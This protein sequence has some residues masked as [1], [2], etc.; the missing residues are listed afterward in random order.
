MSS[1]TFFLLLC[2]LPALVSGNPYSKALREVEEWGVIPHGLIADDQTH[3]EDFYEV[4]QVSV[5]E[6]A[7]FVKNLR[8]G[9]AFPNASEEVGEDEFYERAVANV[10]WTASQLKRVSFFDGYAFFPKNG[11]AQ[12]LRNE[13]A[14]LKEH[15]DRVA[16]IVHGNGMEIEGDSSFNVNLVFNRSVVLE[17]DVPE[18]LDGLFDR[19]DTNVRLDECAAAVDFELHGIHVHVVMNFADKL[20]PFIRDEYPHGRAFRSQV[21]AATTRGR[22][23]ARI[24]GAL[25]AALMGTPTEFFEC[26]I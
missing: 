18:L 9:L 24:A 26:R 13:L 10:K 5:P 20:S 1:V 3:L 11:T 8:L 16:R 6:N 21:T 4:E 23:S 14:Y 17:A 15:L 22:I 7:K 25:L 2:F 12:D 19:N